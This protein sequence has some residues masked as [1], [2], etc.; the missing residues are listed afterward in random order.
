MR[1]SAS[2]PTKGTLAGKLS[3]KGVK[4]GSTAFFMGY[5]PPLKDRNYP[6]IEA[7]LIQIIW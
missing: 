4:G 7:A 1:S 2:G 5:N 6:N 3:I